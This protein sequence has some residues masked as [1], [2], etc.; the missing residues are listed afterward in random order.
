MDKVAVPQEDVV[1]LESITPDV[2]GLRVLIVNVYAISTSAREWVLVD[3]GLPHS[4]GRIQRWAE[5]H[6][7]PGARPS[8]IVL[9]HGHF[10]HTGSVEEL[11]R[12]WDVPVYVHSLEL[13]YV[14]GKAEYPPPDPTV[15]GGLMALLSKL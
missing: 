9:T 5:E 2:S 11:A 15:G 3:C 13:P 14:T 10:D 1:A 4:Q 6:F 12:E 8:S 7:G